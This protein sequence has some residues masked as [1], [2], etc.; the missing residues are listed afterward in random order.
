MQKKKCHLLLVAI[1]VILTLIFSFAQDW[2]FLGFESMKMDTLASESTPTINV[3]HSPQNPQDRDRVYITAT[4]SNGSGV[5]M[6]ILSWTSFMIFGW[7]GT[8]WGWGQYEWLWGWEW[9]V[10]A[11]PQNTTMTLIGDDT[12]RAE[13]LELPYRTKVLYQV[14]AF[15]NEGKLVVASNVNYYYVVRGWQYYLYTQ[16]TE[17]MTWIVFITVAYILISKVKGPKET[18]A[19]EKIENPS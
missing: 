10:W 3:T 17:S 12:Y 19:E 1:P 8:N 2:L 6:V 14:F 15:D 7:Y 18:P 16:F 5:E 11:V 4:L 9:A 13:L